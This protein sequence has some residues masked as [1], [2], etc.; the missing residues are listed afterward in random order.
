MTSRLLFI[1][2]FMIACN[3]NCQAL[4]FGGGSSCGPQVSCPTSCPVC[5]P[6]SE[7]QNNYQNSAPS[8]S[9]SSSY[10][11]PSYSISQSVPSYSISQSAP[12]YPI[13][14]PAPQFAQQLPTIIS[15]PIYQNFESYSEIPPVQPASTPIV[16]PTTPTY[17]SSTPQQVTPKKNYL[18]VDVLPVLT[19]TVPANQEQVDAA[20]PTQSSSYKNENSPDYLESG[21]DDSR[22]FFCE[23][24]LKNGVFSIG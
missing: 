13:S 2:A 8:Y 23:L 12:S 18:D 7:Y 15:P 3:S 19:S 1:I 14:Q 20:T 17:V 6:C 24:R 9:A 10:S 5:T 4:F 21:L 16:Q 22:K 11:A